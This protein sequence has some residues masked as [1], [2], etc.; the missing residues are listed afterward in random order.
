MAGSG[1]GSAGRGIGVARS[2]K[3]RL[4]SGEERLDTFLPH[5][6]A[7]RGMAQAG[8]GTVWH[9]RVRYG[10]AGQGTRG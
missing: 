2:G 3:A 8:P 9:G 6:V 1:S 7:G 4:G 5:S 10:P